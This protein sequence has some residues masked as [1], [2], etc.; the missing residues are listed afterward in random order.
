N[1]GDFVADAYRYVMGT[2]IAVANSGGV[3][4][5]IPAGTLTYN[6]LFN[7]TPF[8]NHAA[9]AYVSGQMILDDLEVACR[10]TEALYKFD[11]KAV[12]EN[13]GFRQVS[14]LKFTIDTSVESA[15]IMDENNFF[16]GFSSDARRVKD[17][18][19]LEGEEYV[20][21]E[22]DKIYTIAATDYVLFGSG[23]GISVYS[24]SEPI[25]AS[26]MSDVEALKQYFTEVGVTEQYKTVQDRITVK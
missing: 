5:D 9:S 17:V 21:L 19:V 24:T 22:K 25:V 15:V 18:Y 16:A 13:G 7:I 1:C 20:P 8:Q 6:D 23:D 26:G 11:G 12:G 2:Q 14:G 3:R 10:D 4:A